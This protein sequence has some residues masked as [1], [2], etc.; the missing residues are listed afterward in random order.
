MG[1]PMTES[2]RV[3]AW[4]NIR[5]WNIVNRYIINHVLDNVPHDEMPKTDIGA[6]RLFMKLSKED[7]IEV[8]LKRYKET[9]EYKQE[10]RKCERMEEESNVAW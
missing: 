6:V 2:N 10:Q 4:K 7:G 5:G 1:R 8:K 3:L 9:F